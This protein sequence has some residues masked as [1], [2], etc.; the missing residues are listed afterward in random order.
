MHPTAQ[1]GLPTDLN[2]P[3][4]P[5]AV[6]TEVVEIEPGAAMGMVKISASDAIGAVETQASD[7]MSVVEAPA[8]DPPISVK[9]PHAVALG[10]LGGAKGGRARAEKLSPERRSEIAR[11]AALARWSV[12][13][14]GN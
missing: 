6:A 7:V 10:K 1:D 13:N 14:S 5:I 2:Q 4:V 3:A 11:K 9:N 8:S 12:Q